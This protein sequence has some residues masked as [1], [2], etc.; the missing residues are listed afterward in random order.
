MICHNPKKTF[1]IEYVEHAILTR[2]NAKSS[3]DLTFSFGQSTK[4]HIDPS[5]FSSESE[6]NPGSRSVPPMGSLRNRD[7]L[8]L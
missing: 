1:H 3:L 2:H 5:R 6:N 4:N 7:S 8:C